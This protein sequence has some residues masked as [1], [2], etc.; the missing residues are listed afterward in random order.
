MFHQESAK[1]ADMQYAAALKERFEPTIILMA[2]GTASGKSEY[3]SVYLQNSSAIVLVGTLP[4]FHGA[5]IKITKAFK[6]KKL[7]E[8]HCVLPKSLMVAFVVFLNR[9][10]KFATEHF[11]RTHSSARK[12]LLEVAQAFPD[13][14][15]KIII[16]DVD[17]VDFGAGGS[18]MSFQELFFDTQTALIE[19]L[20]SAQYNEDSIKEAVFR[21]YDTQ[22]PPQT[23]QP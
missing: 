15:I 13:V 6:A 20:R 21:S 23:I 16:S 19:F 18:T 17:Y 10:R 8:V 7:V 9:D 1:L 14:K 3:V 5:K 12:T 4:T 11:F 22:E 2:G